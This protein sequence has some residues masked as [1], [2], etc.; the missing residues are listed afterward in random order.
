MDEVKW[1]LDHLGLTIFLGVVLLG[2]VIATVEWLLD[3]LRDG[4]RSW[5]RGWRWL[6][7]VGQHTLEG[8][9]PHPESATDPCL[10]ER[11]CTSCG[12]LGSSGVIHEYGRA[13]GKDAACVRISTCL[14]CGDERRDTDHRIRTVLGADV[15]SEDRERIPTW[16]KLEACDVVEICVD[17]GNCAI[18]TFQQHDPESTDYS[19]RCRRCGHW[20]AD[21]AD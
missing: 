20:D 3:R 11:R 1:L 5:P 13:G 6:C 19:H 2:V 16:R 10:Y 18:A 12:R 7:R 17:C 14:R 15:D 9:H 21:D 8:Q 4:R